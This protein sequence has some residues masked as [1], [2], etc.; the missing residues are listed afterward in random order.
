M[1]ELPEV[2]RVAR[3]LRDISIDRVV[4]SVTTTEDTIVFADGITHEDFVREVFLSTKINLF[5][6]LVS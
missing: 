5:D 4:E 1:P 6:F 3:L 2:E